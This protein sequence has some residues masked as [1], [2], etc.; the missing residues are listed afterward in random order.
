MIKPVSFVSRA[1]QVANARHA[2][3]MLLPLPR[4]KANATALR[5]HI[6]LDLLRRGK[7]SLHCAHVMADVMFLVTLVADLGFGAVTQAQIRSA[8]VAIE[9]C[10]ECGHR[11]GKWHL[12]HAGFDSFSSM[13]TIYD[14]QLH[15][16]PVG[17]LSLAYERLK[18]FRA[19]QRAERERHAVCS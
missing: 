3:A 1:A 2:K 18:Y 17:V 4:A 9:A 13:V 11:T 10:V 8:E 7:G 12:D 16:A 15:R 19:K 5:I 6:T 14:R